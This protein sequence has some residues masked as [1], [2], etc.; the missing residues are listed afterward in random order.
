MAKNEAKKARS[1][2]TAHARSG[3]R[4][5][6]HRQT[7]D[8]ARQH[9]AAGR[10]AQAESRCQQILQTD[11]NQP[12]ALHLLG[13]IAHH[14][15]NN[16]R[17]VELISRAV[18]INPHDTDAHNTLGVA[19][20]VL[21]RVEE[22]ETSYRR[23]LAIKPDSVLAHCN[24]VEVL[25]KSNRTEALREALTKARRNCR[26]HPRLALGEAQLLKRDGDYAAARAVLEE[27]S[28][29][30]DEDNTRFLVERA[31]LLG[32]L[33]DRLD[34]VEAA[35]DYFREGN[36]RSRDTPEA[37]RSDA[38]RYLDQ[39]DVLAKRFTAGWIADWQAAESSDGRPDPVFLVGFPRSGTTLLD[40]ILRS[41]GTITVVEEK[42]T[43]IGMANVLGFPIGYPYGLADLDPPQLSEL[44]K[45]YFAE[46]DKHLEP[47]DRSVIAIDKMPLY[48]V[49]AGLIQRVFPQARFLFVQRHP[50]DC[51][52]SCFMRNFGH[53]DAM[54]NLLDL[55]DA[56]RLYDKVMSL[57]RQY[58]AVLPLAVHTVRYER[59][60]EAFE[61]T[62]APALDFLGVGWDDGV[63]DYAE[64]AR[65]RGK[66]NTPSYDQV[67]QP[68]YT[69]ARGRWERYREQMRPVLPLLL[70]W[71]KRC[72]YGA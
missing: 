53:N 60:V 43:V 18:A 42:P 57:W 38:G 69:R 45:T 12:D 63:Q 27:V 13:E 3:H 29:P 17:A 37:R 20:R 16:S 41:H 30:P 25:E 64:T 67:T 56:A 7:L 59:L 2:H 6:P 35:F 15:G 21:G 65:R 36:L 48:I 10:L 8:L 72:G 19:L 52:L 14:A 11:P 62:L 23:A 22:A 33:C 34:D 55:E 66:V 32:E 49:H 61:E 47:Q 24:L 50:C 5:S 68:L 46:L 1:R 28:E 4:N 26:G 40:T 51:V 39:I 9:Y 31:Y 71:A 44:R 70:P 58:R 54:A